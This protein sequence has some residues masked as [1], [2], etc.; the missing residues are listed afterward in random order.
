LT[1]ER[2]AQIEELF[3]RAIECEPKERAR[4]LEDSCAGDV[5]LRREVEAL[6]S[7]A[8]SGG[9]QVRAAV[10]EAMRSTRFPLEGVTVSHYLILGGLGSGGMGVVYKAE[11]LRLGRCVALKFLPEELANNRTALERF[12]R[13]A[14]AASALNHPNICVVHDIDKFEGRPFIVMELLKGQTLKERIAIPLTPSPSPQGRGEPESL[15]VLP[16]PSGPSGR[17]CPDLVGTGEGAR[18][19]PLQIDA[20]LDLAIQIADGLEAAHGEGI[21][22]RDIKP[23]NI[24]VTARGQAKILDFG[25]AKLA[26]SPGLRPPSPAGAGEEL[27]VRGE[28]PTASI[29]PDALTNPGVAIG[30]VAYMSP[31]QARGEKL[32]ARTDLFSFGAV[33]YEMATG[34]MAFSGATTA[35]IHDAILNRAPTSPVQLNP[36]LS[37]ELDR[38]I[39]KALEKDRDLRYHS[40]GD[41]RADLKRLRRDS[42]SA[43]SATTGEPVVSGREQAKTSGGAKVAAALPRRTRPPMV[44]AAVLLV[45]AAAATLAWFSTHRALPPSHLEQRRLTANPEESRVWHAAI[46]PDGKYLAYDDHYGIHVQL[47]ET[48]E[49]HTLSIPTGGESG[50]IS[51][52]LGAWYPDS[53][54]LIVE[55][56]LPGKPSSA[57]VIPILGGAPQELG[58]DMRVD[59]VSPDGSQIMFRRVSSMA[60]DREIWLMGPHGESPHRILSA[61]GESAFTTAVWSPTGNRIAYQHLSSPGR[62]GYLTVT[63][64]SCDLSGANQTTLLSSEQSGALDFLDPGA[65][66]PFLWLP[67]GRLIYSRWSPDQEGHSSSNLWELSVD[68]QSGAAH[69]KPR[70]LTEWSGFD[71]GSLTATSDGKR[72]AFVRD[73]SHRSVFVG[74]LANNGDQLLNPRRLTMDEYQNWPH[75]WTADSRSVVFTSARGGHLGIYK[76]GVDGTTPQVIASSPALDMDVPRLSPDGSWV[77]FMARPHNPPPGTDPHLYR[78]PLSGGVPEAVFP[79]KRAYGFFW[80]TSRAA[81]FCSYFSRAADP[82][83]LILTA[84]DALGGKGKELLR[85]PIEPTGG[86]IHSMSPEGSQVAISKVD[87]NAV[88]VR[89]IPL[90]GQG[91]RTVPLDDYTNINSLLWAADSRSVFLGAF[92]AGFTHLLHLDLN[93]KVQSIWQQPFDFDLRGIASPDGRHLASGG[94]SGDANVWM[95]E[96]F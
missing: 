5:E 64:A 19:A 83:E 81:G 93:G 23:A 57:W 95:I 32:D 89:F 39:N 22:H 53:T 84:F 33:L 6:L 60:G 26:P 30:T 37:G 55:L 1:P 67:S 44:V 87:W 41:L 14:R 68:P 31:E 18:G 79:M 74:D 92:K 47:V 48:G 59:A 56:A 91:I 38:I 20:V 62:E 77:V 85:I 94:L 76:Q 36:D 51:W 80:C 46:S 72:L 54:H 16:S 24:F 28:R 52:S 4:L 35:M 65:W 21:I 82:R 34:K 8:R 70:H 90:H 13:E 78:V 49:T 43:K 45:L 9:G 40:A 29:D 42:T 15:D 69:G 61:G 17:G 75:A 63:L 71:I 50:A 2:W 86:Y 27:G 11:D 10:H 66:P 73:S 58:E 96:N 7:G 88:Q 12:E 3:H 25:L